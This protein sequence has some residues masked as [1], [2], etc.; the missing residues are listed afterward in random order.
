MRSFPFFKKTK[1][2]PKRK[3]VVD[4]LRAQDGSN[5]SHFFKKLFTNARVPNRNAVGHIDMSVITT[6]SL[7]KFPKNTL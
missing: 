5:K 7:T 1:Q 6:H 4:R 3:Q 2:R